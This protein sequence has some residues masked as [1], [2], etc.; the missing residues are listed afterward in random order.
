VLA[1]ERIAS[2]FANRHGID[3][4]DLTRFIALRQREYPGDL[5]LLLVK[6][7][8]IMEDQAPSAQAGEAASTGAGE[9]KLPSSADADEWPAEPVR[10]K[11]T[12]QQAA[13]RLERFRAQ[14]ER[15]TSMADMARRLGCRSTQTIHKAI[16]STPELT[17]WAKRLPGVPRAV[18]QPRTEEAEQAW[19]DNPPPSRELDP[20]DDAAIREFIE[21][22]DPETRAWFQALSVPDQLAVLDDPNRHDKTFPRP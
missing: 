1:A 22:A 3:A 11:T 10:G 19:A 17:A 8:R 4:D 5:E 7:G 13:E 16:H 12:W 15:W 18:G 14:G 6:L 9:A 21:Q 2:T 20:E